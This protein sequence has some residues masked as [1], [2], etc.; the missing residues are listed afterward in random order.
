MS[1]FTFACLILGF[2]AIDED[3]PSTEEDR[4]VDWIGATLITGGLILIV[5][6][7]SDMP[8][9]RDGW[10]N[11]RET[12]PSSRSALT[13]PHVHRYCRALLR[14]P[15]LR[16]TVCSVA[17]LL[18][19]EAWKYR[20]PSYALDGA[21]THE[22]VD[23]DSRSRSLRGD[24]DYRVR[25]LGS[26]LLLVGL[27]TAILPNIPQSDPDPNYAPY[28]AHVLLRRCGK[29]H[30]GADHWTHRRRLHSRCVVGLHLVHLMVSPDSFT[31]PALYLAAVGTLLTGC[32]N[33]YFAAIDPSVSYWATGFPSAC[34][35]VI[36]AD[37]TFASGTM[38]ISKVS[39]L[40]DQSVAGGLFQAMTQIGSA[41]GLSVSTIVFNGVLKAQSPSLGV[42]V[43]QGGDDAPREAQLKAYQA[44][45]WTGFAFGILCGC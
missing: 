33:I 1:G 13:C 31:L 32:A 21:A 9:A 24:A 12:H 42:S 19:T 38:F 25:Q 16:P 44:A 29:Y 34:L 18:G 3:E 35:V 23:V 41:I 6:V 8:T 39:P 27:G 2:F 20:S 30:C 22:T 10:K 43:D 5:F 14:R 37:F 15:L 40:S 26:F 28:I 45:M 11:P 7:L 36:G 17:I 4:R